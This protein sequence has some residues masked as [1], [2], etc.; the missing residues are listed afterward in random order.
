MIRAA[1]KMALWS[2]DSD[3]DQVQCSSST[4][5]GGRLNPTEVTTGNLPVSAFETGR[6]VPID[7]K[8][9]RAQTFSVSDS[10]LPEDE[11]ERKSVVSNVR[12]QEKGDRD[13]HRERKHK[14]TCGSYRT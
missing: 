14:Q 4:G 3:A 11:K 5:S 6:R 2:F 7:T 12:Q 9:T 13:F 10:I 8:T 1:L